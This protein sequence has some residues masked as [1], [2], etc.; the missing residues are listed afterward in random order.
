M[1]IRNFFAPKGASKTINN[2]DKPKAKRKARMIESD[3]E[4]DEPVKKTKAEDSPKTK[5]KPKTTEKNLKPTD[6]DS[7]FGSKP[8][9]R[10]NDK[11][12][13]PKKS[14]D[15]EVH[16]DE[17]FMET[18][19]QHDESSTSISLSR[20]LASKMK[21][22]VEIND[23]DDFKVKNGKDT[24]PDKDKTTQTESS[25]SPTKSTAELLVEKCVAELASKSKEKEQETMKKSPESKKRKHDSSNAE[26]KTASPSKKKCS[27]EKSKVENKETKSIKAENE[28]KEKVTNNQSTKSITSEVKTKDIKTEGKDLKLSGTSSLWV[29]KYAPT[30]TKQIIGQQGERSNVKK[31]IKWLSNWFSNHDGTKKLSRPSPWAKDDDGAFFKAALLSG[32]PGVG[33]T[34]TAHLVSKELD[35]DVVEMNASDT[36]SKKL[37]A[38]TFAEMLSNKSLSS[39]VNSQKSGESGVTKRH[40]LLMDEV[41]GMAGNEDRGGVAE[42]ILL[43]K[44]SRVPI[45]CM[46]NDRNSPKIRSLA[47][48]CFDLRFTKPRPEQIKGAMLSVCFKE[49]INIKPD[50]LMDLI[51]GSNQDI[52]Q[53]LHHLSLW[54][55]SEKAIP[56]EQAKAEANKAKKDF[57]IGP[58]DT[59]KKVFSEADHKSMSI[60]DKS[61]LFFEDYS[62]GPLFVQENYLGVTPSAANG[63][64]TKTLKLVSEASDSLALGDMVEKSIRSYNAWSLLPVQAIY[65]SVLP[66]EYLSGFLNSQIQFPSWFGKNSKQNK[67]ERIL[68]EIQMHTRLKTSGDKQAINRDYLKSLRDGLTGP[69]IKKGLE[70]VPESVSMMI[71]YNLLRED[72]DGIMELSEWPGTFNPM[73]KVETKVKSA[74]TRAYNKE[75]GM[76]PFSGVQT[77]KKKSRAAATTETEYGEDED[78]YDED[79]EEDDSIEA[80]SNIKIKKKTAASKGKG[81]DQS[82]GSGSTSSS[83]S[84]GGGR[85]RKKK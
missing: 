1:D 31:L 84:R 79:D 69:L 72:L 35:F 10:S 44:N 73:S 81:K 23:C 53:V 13:A 9:K 28:M 70:G 75:G 56:S 25:K 77:A 24:S 67:F 30:T 4:D 22:K 38:E 26:N 18:L 58:F 42:L 47:G 36:R 48:H 15:S 21:N 52:R 83:S 43:I 76:N 85:G 27:P 8:I 74:F 11:I 68:Q 51:N 14:V 39:F 29:D 61:G 46:C 6:V 71:E 50:A 59:V 20:K 49:K 54:S 62:L 37:M 17:K 78:N 32:P 2:N 16:A 33:K 55:A 12:F 57:K 40:V 34:T 60:H 82:G 19:D 3:S 65:S 64:R 45:I 66:G 7:F 80:D 5:I 63:S 41:D